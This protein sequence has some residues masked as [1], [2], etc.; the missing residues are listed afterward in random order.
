MDVYF[1]R[2]L[3]AG[4]TV[5]AIGSDFA[6]VVVENAVFDDVMDQVDGATHVAEDGVAILS[7]RSTIGMSQACL[8]IEPTK[9]I[10]STRPDETR[11]D[12]ESS[13]RPHTHKQTRHVAAE[14]PV[15]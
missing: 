2:A 11:P 10:S 5:A 4:D 14:P 7:R 6:V 3:V 12:R 8:K 9:E 13:L 15:I 1:F